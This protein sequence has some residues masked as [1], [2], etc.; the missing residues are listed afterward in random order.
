MNKTIEKLRA[1]CAPHG[2]EVD[3]SRDSLLDG[4]GW[5]ITF[6]A[7]PLMCWSTTQATVVCF[8]DDSLRGIVSFIRKELEDGFY[9]ADDEALR[10]TGQGRWENDNV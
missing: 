8:Q 5:D 3:A 7:P 1:I 2:V 9:D 10:L 6:D 4:G